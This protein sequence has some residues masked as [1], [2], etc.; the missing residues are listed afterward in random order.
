MSTSADGTRRVLCH[1][2]NSRWTTPV[3]ALGLGLAALLVQSLR[4]DVGGGVASLVIM[5]VYAAVLVVFGRRSEVVSLLRGGSS[6]ER[7]DSITNR[8]LAATGGVLVLVLVG[9]FLVELARGA[10]DVGLWSGLCGLAGATF[11]VALAVLSRRS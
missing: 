2:Q 5:S 3:T 1:L 10:D 7:R 4:G 9:G 6:D 11:A 8:A